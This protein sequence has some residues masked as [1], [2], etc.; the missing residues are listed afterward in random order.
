MEINIDDLI[1]VHEESMPWLKHSLILVARAGS[2]SHGTSTPTSDLDFKG[3]AIPP[4][5]YFLGFVK[6][7]EQAEQREP[8][9]AVI[10]DIRK[11]FN[12]AA[13]CNPSIIETLFVDE[14]DLIWTSYEGILLRANAH[15]FL[16]RKAKHTFGG[17]AFSQLGRIKRHRGWLLHPPT[18]EPT[19]AKYGLPET[20][21][22][23]ADQRGMALAAIQKKLEEWD[24]DL[25][26]VDPATRI[27]IKERF[28]Q[29]LYDIRVNADD[30][31]V[32]AAR[33]I[34]ASDAFIDILWKERAYNNARTEWKQYQN[35]KATRNPAR[36][37]LEAHYGYDTKHGMHL[38]RLMRMGYEILTT[39]KVYVKRPDAEELLAIRAGAWSYDQ[40]VEYADSMEK[41]MNEA[42]TSSPLPPAPDRNKLD[43]ICANLITQR[44][45]I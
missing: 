14:S 38:V 23:P 27:A 15:L 25:E 12:L 45:F 20:T 41:K 13:D 44:R 3:V 21:T 35:W 26:M 11:F 24:P 7:F 6:K 2:H 39:G 4:R 17:Y 28:T 34:G 16:S 10:Y 31:W 9:D 29:V 5:E 36:A 22:I 43:I 32:Q 42:Y 40:I 37:E 8:Y 19:R 1:K 18:E 33:S 30:L